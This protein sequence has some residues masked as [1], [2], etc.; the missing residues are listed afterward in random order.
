MIV[1]NSDY[2]V[3]FDHSFMTPSSFK[4]GDIDLEPMTT[5]IQST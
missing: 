5:I 1:V 2:N 4:L 3:M